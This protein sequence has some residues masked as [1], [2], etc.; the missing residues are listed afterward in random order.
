MAQVEGSGMAIR[1]R[2][3]EKQH[4]GYGELRTVGCMGRDQIGLRR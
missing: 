3:V 4:L 1:S 2:S